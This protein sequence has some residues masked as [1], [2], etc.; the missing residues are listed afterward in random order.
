[1]NSTS[2]VELTNNL[3]NT[4]H[5]NSIDYSTTHAKFVGSNILHAKSLHT[6]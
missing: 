6:I 1:M 3:T 5:E 4:I 2:G